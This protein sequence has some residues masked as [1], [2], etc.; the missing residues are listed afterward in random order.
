MSPNSS[1]SNA[2]TSGELRAFVA[3]RVGGYSWV[4]DLLPDYDL[5]VGSGAECD[6]RVELP[7][8]A[9]KH[10]VLRWEG[11]GLKVTNLGAPDS[12]LINGE[13]TD[14]VVEFGP[15]DEVEIGAAALVVNIT[16]APDNKGRRSLTHAEFSE[17]LSEELA[18]AG[19]VGRSTCLMMLKSKS[20]DGSRLAAVALDSF[21]GGDI[22][23]TYAHD[24][25]EFLLPDTPPNIAR[26]VVL[27][28]IERAGAEGAHVGLAIAPADGDTAERCVRAARDALAAAV[29]TDQTIAHT[30]MSGAGEEGEEVHP[31]TEATKRV[32]A[33]IT[34]AAT[35]DDSDRKSVV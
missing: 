23:G 8:M 7:S 2:A 14:G 11:G 19:R 9:D 16:L 35:S 10:A 3:T 1:N 17:R 5:T 15:G 31:H 18:R 29:T 20:G 32:I 30:G 34:N 28:M 6:V 26:A 13:P 27:R 33:D 4:V 12:V 24:E 25:I 22:V 21:R